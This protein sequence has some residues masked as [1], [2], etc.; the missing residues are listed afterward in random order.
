MKKVVINLFL[1]GILLSVFSCTSKKNELPY[2]NTPDFTPQWLEKS[3]ANEKITHVIDRFNFTDQNATVF[4]N[5]NLKDKIHVANFFFTSCPGICPKMT[6][7]LGLV[8]TKFLNEDQLVILSYT[9]TPWAD[10]VSRLKQYAEQYEVKNKRWHLLTGKKSDIYDLARKS[11]FAEEE[12]GF[13]KDSTNFL[14]TEHMLLVDKTGRLRGIY[15]GT[16]QLEAERLI[17]DIGLLLK[18]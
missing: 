12:P 2:Y 15:N 10:S 18:E 14:H 17:E 16:L 5:E 9:V 8:Q 3:E 7:Y 13:D 11:Y 6:N 4:S 1:I